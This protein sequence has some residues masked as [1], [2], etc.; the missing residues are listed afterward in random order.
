MEKLQSFA[1]KLRPLRWILALAVMIGFFAT[2]LTLFLVPSSLGFALAGPLVIVPWCLMSI[3]FARNP[4]NQSLLFALLC[5]GVGVAW[6]AIVL[7]G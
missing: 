5:C 1:K 6:P 4:S 3:S 7:L 2:G